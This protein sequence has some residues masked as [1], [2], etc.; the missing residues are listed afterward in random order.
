MRV[1]LIKTSS[2][3]DIIHTLPAL[4]DAQQRYPNLQIDWVVERAFAEIPT[5]HTAVSDVIPV[6]IRRWRKQLCRAETWRAWSAY[7]AR[8]QARHYDKVIDAQGLLKSAFLATRLAKG[9]K[10]GYDAQSAREGISSLFYDRRFHIP[11][12]QHAVERIRHL[13][14]DALGYDRP[15]TLGDYAIAKHFTAP[16]LESPYLVAVHSTTRADK[17]WDEKQW[18]RLFAILQPYGMPILLP[19]G[20]DAEKARAERLAEQAPHLRVLP[21]M[22]LSGL[23]GILAHAHAV[24]SVDT[25]LSH[26]TA[27]LDTPNVIL[28]GATDPKLIG[29][30]GQHQYYIQAQGMENIQP[31]E[32]LGLMVEHNMLIP[33]SPPL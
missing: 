26:L 29:A 12:R 20:N 23:A 27:A 30:Y 22:T 17:H 31:E 3:G 33:P 1:C 24:I 25:G 8:L 21:R 19:W 4:T 28:Y 10:Y 13:F 9:T 2:M 7:K 18:H 14:A 16:P 6:E 32:V 5:W 15:T 11:Y